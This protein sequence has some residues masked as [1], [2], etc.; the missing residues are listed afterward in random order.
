MDDV[1]VARRVTAIG[2]VTQV[3]YKK[4]M[5]RSFE[6]YPC[7]GV[8]AFEFSSGCDGQSLPVER[9]IFGTDGPVS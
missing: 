4:R 7:S 1:V 2:S 5:V 9:N 3:E 8:L 6:T